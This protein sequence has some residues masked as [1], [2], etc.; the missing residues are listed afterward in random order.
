M[1]DISRTTLQRRLE[2]VP[3]LKEFNSQ[4]RKLKLS[5]E[6]TLVQ[7]ILNLDQRGFPPQIIGV[8]RMADTLLAARGSNPPPQPVGKNWVSRFIENQPEL[9]TKWNR[10]FHSQR[11][12]CEDPDTINAWFKRVQETRQLYGILDDDSYNFDE[13]GFMMG[14]IATSRV[15]ISSDTIGRAIVVQP[16]NREWTTAIEGINASGWAI[17]PFVILAGKVHQSSWYRDLPA[18]WVIA[19]SD[20]GWTT[21]ELGFE[22]IKHFNTHTESRTKGTHR[23]LILDGHNSHTTPEFDQYCTANNIVTLCMP[24]HTSHLLQPLDVSCF[25]PLKRSYGQEVQELVRQRIH[26]IDKED[27]LTIYSKIRP[28]VFTDQNI[29]SG[30]S[31]TGLI[32]YDPQRVLSSPT[33]TKT[34]SPPGTANG[35]APLWTSETLHTLAQL[36]QQA[37]LIQDLLQRQSQS[38]TNQAVSQLVKGCQLAMNSAILL[39]EDNRKLRAEN[40]RRKQKQQHRRRYIAQGGALQ[41]QQ[42]QFLVQRIENREQEANQNGAVNV[43]RRALPTCSNCHIQGHTIR[44][45]PST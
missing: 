36:E 37:R 41:A 14:V 30:F 6:Q 38:P 10:K 43:R 32:P 22:W 29:K 16:G 7:W 8:R 24:A 42:G 40:Q 33:I 45:C 35:E 1:Y 20:N 28:F 13:T 2:K 34:P 23:L 25:S 12:K 39:A 15:V 3:T 44:Q 11:A 4:K 5:E 9:K 17:P 19:V 31:A 27:F 26:H 18:N 21:D